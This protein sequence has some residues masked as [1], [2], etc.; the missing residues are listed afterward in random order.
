V[1]FNR[2]AASDIKHQLK[3][4]WHVFISTFAISLYTVSNVFI[5]GLFTNNTIVGYYSAAEKLIKAAQG[6]LTPI[7]QS[8]YPFISEVAAK[9]R[10]EALRFIRKLVRFV[11]GGS[12]VVSLLTFIFAE[13]IINI[14]LGSQYQ[15]SVIVLRIL[16]FL[17]F[18][19]GLS[20][21]LGVQTMLTFDFKKAFS[22]ILV[23][24]GFLN[25]CLALI[26][27][28]LY[29]HIGVSIAVLTTETFVTICMFFYLKSK[30]VHVLGQIFD[31]ED[32]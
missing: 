4:G 24:A 25:I 5:L 12:F 21:I 32:K 19:I 14:A 30:G 31:Y 7:S 3:E 10:Q 1:R 22:R 9:S 18:I 26:L 16:A 2:P 27:V 8:V 23:C 13:F 17:P 15:R 6:L 11:G 29:R 20:N 28:P